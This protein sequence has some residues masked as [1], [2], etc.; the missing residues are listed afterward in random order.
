[1]SNT[2]SMVHIIAQEPLL[3]WQLLISSLLRYAF[4][5]VYRNAES[6]FFV[7]LY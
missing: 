4:P 6:A 1:M 2:I 7:S 5:S 3:R